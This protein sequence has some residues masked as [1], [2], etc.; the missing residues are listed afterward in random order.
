MKHLVAMLVFLSFISV[1][2]K[3]EKQ[4]E[5]HNNPPVNNDSYL[6]MEVGNYWKTNDQNYTEIRGTKTIHDQLFYEFFSLV[7]GDAVSVRYLRINE[8]GDL[9]EMYPDGS[10]TV[11][12]HAKFNAEVGDIFYTTGE[13]D[14]NDYMVKLIEKED[15]VI[16]FEWDMAY[17]PNLKGHKFYHSYK[18]GF[19]YFGHKEI[20]IGDDIYRF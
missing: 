5:A 10:S 19:G 17:H 11:Y 3:K 12:T 15:D 8:N 13:E 14:W 1:G 4:A 2:C 9:I 20:K 7:G 6:P 16:K 18:K